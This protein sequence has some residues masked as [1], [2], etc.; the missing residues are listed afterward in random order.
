MGGN[1]TSVAR[2]RTR[3]RAVPRPRMG[4]PVVFVTLVPSTPPWMD[5]AC[6][7]S[8]L[9][10]FIEFEAEDFH[11][12]GHIDPTIFLPFIYCSNYFSPREMPRQI[13]FSQT[14]VAPTISPQDKSHFNY[15]SPRQMLLQLY[16]SQI[17]AAPAIFYAD[18]Y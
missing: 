16:S 3:P 2:V 13:F 4:R 8:K 11:S 15:F 5:T 12:H 6:L 9:F 14:N 17:N 10:M 1:A 7:V 18:K